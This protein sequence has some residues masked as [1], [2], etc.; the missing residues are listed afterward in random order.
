MGLVLCGGSLEE[1]LSGVS[2]ARLHLKI[3]GGILNH[4]LVA[5]ITGLVMAISVAAP[6]L[7][8]D[9]GTE[10]CTPG[11]WKNHPEAWVNFSP[12]Q[13]VGSVFEGESAQLSGA[14]LM[15]ALSFDGGDGLVGAERILL[16]AAVASILNAASDIDFGYGATRIINTTDRALLSD[17]RNRMIK[18]AAEWDRMNNRGCP[19]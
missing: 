5:L 12:N 17:N 2:K 4:K 3:L 18:L 10:G 6:A 8:W 13:T 7:A 19:L 16:R 14:T 11:Y 1:Q 9:K 15:E